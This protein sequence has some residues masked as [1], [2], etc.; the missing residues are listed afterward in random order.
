ME[1]TGLQ[2]D[3]IWALKERREQSA[4]E[5]KAALE[6]IIDW[7]I[8]NESG[9]QYKASIKKPIAFAKARMALDNA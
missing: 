1:I 8:E 5:L 6:A 9:D 2:S 4:N 7:A 3:A